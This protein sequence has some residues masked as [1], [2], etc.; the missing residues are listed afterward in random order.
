MQRKILFFDIDGTLVSFHTHRIPQS[1]VDAI[2]RA[3]AEGHIVVIATGRPM[4]II[5]NLGPLQERALIDGYITMNGALVTVGDRVLHSSV[6]DPVEV[7]AMAEVCRSNNYPCIF[8]GANDMRVAQPDEEV[9]H[10]FREY[11]NVEHIDPIDITHG[12]D[13]PIYQLTPFFNAVE[14]KSIEPLLPGCEFNRWYPTFVD[15]TARGCTKALGMDV[16]LRHFGLTRD[17]AIAFGDGG[18]DL[19]MLLA[20]GTGVAM[21]NAEADIRSQAD[22]VT[23]S[24]DDDGIALAIRELLHC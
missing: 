2:A 22:H 21:G 23:A 24:V 3:H 5:N 1:A 10:V 12:A 17:D 4:S 18:N 19:P 14:Q 13:R 6:I 16:M 11:L 8:V 9:R 15:V 7:K 20:A